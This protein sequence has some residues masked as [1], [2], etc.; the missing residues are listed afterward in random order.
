MI[1]IFINHAIPTN[2]RKVDLQKLENGAKPFVNKTKFG[3]TLAPSS[4]HFP[5]VCIT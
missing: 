4:I 2:T 3:S 1:E 5:G